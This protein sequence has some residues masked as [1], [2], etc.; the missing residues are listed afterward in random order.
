[1]LAP[2]LLELNHDQTKAELRLVPNRHGPISRDDIMALLS[3][4]TCSSFYP[5]DADIEKFVIETNILC[6]QS[7]GDQELGATIA[8]RRD[9][10]VTIEIS[11]D[12][13]L[14]SMTLSA[15][16]G[17]KELDLA[18]ILVQLKKH[19]V[20]M[21]LSKQK[22]QNLLNELSRLEAGET[23]QDEIAHGRLPVNGED[24][25]LERKVPLARERL[26]QPQE[27]A[28]GTVDMRNLGAL[29]MVKPNDLLML[30]YPATT[31]VTG[32]NVLG[33]ALAQKPGKDLVLQVGTGTRLHPEDPNKLIASVSGQPVE[34]RG[35][36]SVDDVLQLRNVDISTGH[37]N[38]KGSILVTG[39]VRE[40]MEVKSTGDIT[41]MG[42]VDSAT[43]QA[44]GDI[45]VRKGVIGRQVR[46]NEFSTQL[47]AQGQISAQFVQYSHLVAKG[48]I[49]ITKQLLHSNSKTAGTLTVSDKKGYRGDLVGGIASAEKGLCAVA[50]GATAGTKTEVHCAMGLEDLKLQLKL[51]DES[52]KTMVITSFE[53]DTHLKRLPPKAEWQ[54]D[55][56]MVEQ[57]NLMVAEKNRLT[58]ERIRTEAELEEVRHELDGYY[59]KYRINVLTHVFP[60]AEFHIGQANHKT[61]REH[62]PCTI[63]NVGQEIHF[64]YHAK[65]KT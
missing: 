28:D 41:V 17:G 38:F 3:A 36:M 18:D 7:D 50:I 40:G 25:R 46:V 1:M 30:K 2:E 11:P 37:I 26:L 44:D 10:Q 48:D 34:S 42:F 64:D 57:V 6:Q 35:C 19:N 52:A 23:C 63:S 43:L 53:L 55:S 15:A 62:G 61:T 47:T 16:W 20:R 27:R 39:D 54:D 12:K 5:L 45:T 51:L 59:D 32:Y 22:I 13:M 49:L 65:T 14:A 29:F 56:A 58:N 60:N 33:E 4:S 21:G 9:G 8:E 24:A 31:G